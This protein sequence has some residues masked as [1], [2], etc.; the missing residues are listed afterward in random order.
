[1]NVLTELTESE[2]DI[3]KEWSKEGKGDREREGG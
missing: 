3:R 2:R 1:M